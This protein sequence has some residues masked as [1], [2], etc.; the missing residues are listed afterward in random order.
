MMKSDF[1]ITSCRGGALPSSDTGTPSRGARGPQA[2]VGTAA[3]GLWPERWHRARAW[4]MHRVSGQL[5][6]VRNPDHSRVVEH[7]LQRDAWPRK[8]RE[9]LLMPDSEL[10]I[11]TVFT[12]HLLCAKHY[13]NRSSG[14]KSFS[15]L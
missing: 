2:H 10:I 13:C 3:L 6:G 14:S 9:P 11:I 8:G 1:L 4:E 15:P 5:W 12:E 7:D